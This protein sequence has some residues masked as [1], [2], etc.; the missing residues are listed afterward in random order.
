MSTRL[1]RFFA[2][3]SCAFTLSSCLDYEE[4]LTIHEDLSGEAVVTIHLPDTLLGKFGDAA[5]QLTE[6][7]LRKR[8]DALSGVKLTSYQYT[9]GRKPVVTLGIQFSSLEKLSEA[10]AGNKPA[11]VLVGQFTIT[12]EA[13]KNVIERKLGVGDPVNDLP[14]FNFA[15]YTTHFDGTIA[16]TNSGFFNNHNSDVRYRYKL[17]EILADQP[18][19]RN[20]IVKPTPWVLFGAGAI[21]VIAA[22]WFI[23][24]KMNLKKTR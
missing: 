10:A 5:D 8:F 14:D 2:A 24:N 1:C 3:L 23:W 16:K 11:S 18:V 21:A 20:E 17:T 6:A 12:K 9:E 13:G 7:N 19:M 4:H 22:A 15:N